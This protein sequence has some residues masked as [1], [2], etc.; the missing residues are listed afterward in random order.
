MEPL[1]CVLKLEFVTGGW[2]MS[3]RAHQTVPFMAECGPHGWAEIPWLR[4][5]NRKC[6]YKVQESN[7]AWIMSLLCFGM[8]SHLYRS[9]RGWKWFRSGFQ[10]TSPSSQQDCFTHHLCGGESQILQNMWPCLVQTGTAEI[11]PS[12]CVSNRRSALHILLDVFVKKLE[13][14]KL[15]A[16]AGRP[17]GR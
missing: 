16:V 13:L 14:G 15:S 5:A 8:E 6:V 2:V 12:E 4:C 17:W 1:F 9:N 11:I 3:Q 7:F 10:A